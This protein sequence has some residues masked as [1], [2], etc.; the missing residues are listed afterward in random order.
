MDNQDLKMTKRILITGATG[1]IGHQVIRYL[2]QLNTNHEVVAGVRN[3]DKAKK[4]LV[5]YTDLT[6]TLFDFE[7]ETTFSTALKNID[8][9][10]LLRPPHIADIEKYF[11]PLLTSIKEALVKEI[12]FLSVQGAERSK[13]IPHHKIEALIQEFELDYIFLRPSY[14]MQNLTTTLHSTIKEKQKIIL[15]SGKAV[16]NWI[17]VNNIGEVAAHLI[18][19]FIKYKNSAI[20]LTG[21]EN[22]NFFFV[23]ELIRK[24]CHTD[25]TYTAVN[26]FKFFRLKKK[27]GMVQGMILVMI[28]LHFLPRFQRP[29][30]INS[31][32]EEITG[33]KPTPLK[34]FIQRERLKFL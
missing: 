27:E 18:D 19:D 26:P 24:E 17:D 22:E 4:Q 13:V 15:P 2:S 8:T 11:R 33:K 16:F 21:Y 1:N 7:N 23:A 29:P 14:F 12:V 6:Y 30:K 3:I 31:F 32:Y 28:M 20:E 25:L 9:V 10:F 5:V 34:E